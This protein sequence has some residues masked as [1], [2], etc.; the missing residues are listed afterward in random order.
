MLDL[1]HNADVYW[2]RWINGAGT[3]SFLDAFMPLFSDFRIWHKPLMGVAVL[4]VL[5]G[6]YR[7]R[8]FV[9][10]LLL[11][12]F[13]GDTGLSQSIKKLSGRPRPFQVLAG[14]RH[15]NLNGVDAPGTVYARTGNSM[16][17]SHVANM[18]CAAW[19]ASH[20]FYPWGRAAWALAL[21]VAY[22]R[23][24]TGN[25]YPGDILVSVAVALITVFVVHRVCRRTWKKWAPKYAP[26]LYRRYPEL[27]PQKT[28]HCGPAAG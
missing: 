15:V 24:Y 20:I 2:F 18:V 19:L 14:A 25:H 17:S 28:T 27:L 12:L 13:V 11:C 26:V 1:L 22:S 6:K 8:L 9:V 21:I 10:L 7:A 3:S 16:N 23:I 4:L 5:V